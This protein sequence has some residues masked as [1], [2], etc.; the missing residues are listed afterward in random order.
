MHA[1]FGFV[2]LLRTVIFSLSHVMGGSVGSAILVVSL[3]IRI[4]LLPLTI[5]WARRAQEQAR[6]IRELEPELARIR[7]SHADDPAR[8]MEETLALYR[9]NDLGV[10]PKGVLNSILVQ[11]PVN[12]GLYQAIVGGMRRAGGFLWIK[13]LAKPDVLLATAAALLAAAAAALSGTTDTAAKN[14]AIVSG[15]I[16]FLLAWRLSAG[17]GLYW[18]ASNGVGVVQAALTRPEKSRA[19]A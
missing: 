2:D 15:V 7:K 10:L 12:A 9:K 11:L 5:R 1:W 8:V 19:H 17:L 18:L 3:A 13:D 4:A 14:A 6:R 16:T